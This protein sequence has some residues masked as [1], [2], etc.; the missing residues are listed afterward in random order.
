[1]G[2]DYWIKSS[3]F[4]IEPG[5]DKETNPGIYGKSIAKWI[6]AKLSERGYEPEEIIAE[7]WGWCVMCQ[8]KPFYLWVGCGSEFENGFIENPSPQDLIWHC[9]PVAEIPFF[10]I[11]QQILSLLGK[12]D[13]QSQLSQL[14]KDIFEILSAEKGIE[15]TDHP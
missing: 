15:L 5:E 9:F 14:E 2:K 3:L 12:L 13:L 7:D 6:K 4:E 1:M 8:R 10:Q 11:K